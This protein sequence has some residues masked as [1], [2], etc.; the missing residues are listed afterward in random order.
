MKVY[1]YIVVDTEY[2]TYPTV[3]IFKN[4][5]DA[6]KNWRA[7]LAHEFNVRNM[8]KNFIER[9][10]RKIEEEYGISH[11]VPSYCNPVDIQVCED[12]V[13]I[14]GDEYGNTRAWYIQE[15]DAGE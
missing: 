5:E 11:A 2:E 7:N 10:R 14:T 1:A 8:E 13:S 3:T 4:I 15:C 6:R 12:D 9:L